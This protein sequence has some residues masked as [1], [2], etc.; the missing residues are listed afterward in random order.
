ME[1]TDIPLSKR[2]DTGASG[3]EVLL[4]TTSTKPHLPIRTGA[5]PTFGCGTTVRNHATGEV[6][7]SIPSGR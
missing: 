1:R 5:L 4:S 2:G 3:S 7:C 6:V